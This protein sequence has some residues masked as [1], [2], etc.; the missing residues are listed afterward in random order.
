VTS[1]AS[2]A[3][4]RSG[5]AANDPIADIRTAIYAP[6]MLRLIAAIMLM[7]SACAQAEPELENPRLRQVK[8]TGD[9]EPALNIPRGEGRAKICAGRGLPRS[10]EFVLG[11][12]VPLYPARAVYSATLSLPFSAMV[13]RTSRKCDVTLLGEPLASYDGD[14]EHLSYER[15]SMLVREDDVLVAPNTIW[16]GKD[17]FILADCVHRLA[18]Y[19]QGYRG[20]LSEPTDAMFRPSSSHALLVGRPYMGPRAPWLPTT[21]RLRCPQ[22][23]ELYFG[24]DL[25]A[26]LL[27]TCPSAISPPQPDEEEEIVR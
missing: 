13:D 23:V 2:E 12:P 26:S 24:D 8:G 14:G 16:D 15:C 20:A 9:L 17:R 22:L 1:L 7:F 11:E 19:L 6:T 21:L 5:P 18:M 25:A 27:S 3:A 4:A 10:S